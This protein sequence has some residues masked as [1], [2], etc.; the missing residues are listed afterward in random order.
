M[1]ISYED[2]SGKIGIT[3]P[4]SSAGISIGFDGERFV[5]YDGNTPT[6]WS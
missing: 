3:V 2:H 5:V 6:M 1:L 4:T